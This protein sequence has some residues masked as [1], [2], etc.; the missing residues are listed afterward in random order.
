MQSGNFSA[1]GARGVAAQSSSKI[2]KKEESVWKLSDNVSKPDFRHWLDSVD[3]QLEAMNGFAYPDLVLEKV[4]RLPTEVAAQALENIIA[5][6]NE[7]HQKQIDVNSLPGIEP[8]QPGADP[9]QMWLG[10]RAVRTTQQLV[11]D[12]MDMC[13]VYQ[14]ILVHSH[15]FAWW[16]FEG[17]SESKPH[18]RKT[19][20]HFT[21]WLNSLALEQLRI[22]H[23]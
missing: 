3:L 22:S 11:L 12:P 2:D 1:E 8:V 6:I 9:W 23:L 20:H 10:R 7:E 17:E 15:V 13:S 18:R 5:D 19:T 4:K 14:G 21:R 16:G